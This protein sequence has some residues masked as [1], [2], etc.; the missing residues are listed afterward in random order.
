MWIGFLLGEI[1]PEV[2]CREFGQGVLR[3]GEL[4]GDGVHAVRHLIV[5]ERDE[6]LTMQGVVDA[7]LVHHFEGRGHGV[8]PRGHHHL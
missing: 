3:V 4:A 7:V 1:Y 5:R 6:L 2:S 8:R